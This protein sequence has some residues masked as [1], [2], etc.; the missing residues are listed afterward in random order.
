MGIGPLSQTNIASLVISKRGE[1]INKGIQYNPNATVSFG[2]S[3]PDADDSL[4]LGNN[5]KDHTGTCP[6]P[7]F[8]SGMILID[9]GLYM[10]NALYD[11]YD[12]LR[13]IGLQIDPTDDIK[14]IKND[15]GQ[16]VAAIA[17]GGSVIN[18]RQTIRF[19]D[20]DPDSSNVSKAIGALADQPSSS[21]P[22]KFYSSFSEHLDLQRTE[23]PDRFLIN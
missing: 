2:P 16:I 22:L 15:K 8:K 3:Y 21:N 18:Q 10:L 6:S 17:F 19:F 7:E 13:I 20:I 5:R 23:I 14:I 12:I 11:E 4:D 1:M 9:P